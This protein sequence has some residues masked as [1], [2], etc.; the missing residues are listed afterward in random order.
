MKRTIA[1]FFAIVFLVFNTGLVMNIHLCHDKVQTITLQHK[2][3]CSNPGTDCCDDLAYRLS[4]NT[5]FLGH[6]TPLIYGL[7]VFN[8]IHE[9][10]QIHVAQIFLKISEPVQ[11][12]PVH[13]LLSRIYL[14]HRQLLI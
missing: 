14:A 8:F 13:S 1:I 10:E 12:L 7:H 6:A 11:K 9:N 5:D 2:D 3:G 4:I